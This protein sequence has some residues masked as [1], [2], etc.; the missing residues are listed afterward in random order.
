MAAGLVVFP[1]DFVLK[2]VG[3][4]AA[5]GLV[6][7]YLDLAEA[8][9]APTALPT[10]LPRLVLIVLGLAAHHGGGRGVDR[11]E[12]APSPGQRLVACRARAAVDRERR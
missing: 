10:W 5:S 11:K 3:V 2:M 6:R 7:R 9:F 4:S 8:A 12:P 1:I